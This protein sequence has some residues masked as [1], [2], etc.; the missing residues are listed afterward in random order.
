MRKRAQHLCGETAG[1][2]GCGVLGNQLVPAGAIPAPVLAPSDG[3]AVT[4]GS[5]GRSSAG[6]RVRT[7]R[8]AP[9]ERR[10]GAKGG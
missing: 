8:P 2:A 6:A 9:A 7:A 10:A 4:H 3:Q 5:H 1:I